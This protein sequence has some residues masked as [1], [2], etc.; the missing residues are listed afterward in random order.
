MHLVVAYDIPGNRRRQRVARLLKGCGQR[1]QYSVFEIHVS[2]AQL[3]KLEQQLRGLISTK[4]DSVRIYDL[5]GQKT[6]PLCLL[7][8]G[9][10]VEEPRA[11]VV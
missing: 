10:R 11:R 5:N 1:V 3:K 9:V 2:G 4:E 6:R 7:G 8:I